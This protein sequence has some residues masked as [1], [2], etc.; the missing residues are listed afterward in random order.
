MRGPKFWLI[1]IA[2]VLWA[3]AAFLVLAEDRW[4]HLGVGDFL[5]LGVPFFAASYLPGLK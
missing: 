4:G 3:I 2:V 5:V 1:L